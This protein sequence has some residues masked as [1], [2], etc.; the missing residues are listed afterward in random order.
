MDKN[1]K[2]RYQKTLSFIKKQAPPCKVLDLG[3]K[4][5]FSEIMIA[6]GYDV[7]NTK[8]EDLDTNFQLIKQKKVDLVT[9]FEIFEHMLA[10]FNIL[11]TLQVPNLITSIPLKL[12]SCKETIFGSST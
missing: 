4:N 11:R 2:I 6:N 10:P 3:T 5:E 12:A 8:G 9:A 7:I 1:K